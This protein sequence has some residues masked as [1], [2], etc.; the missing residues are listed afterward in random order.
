[1]EKNINEIYGANR[2]S[3]HEKSR[4]PFSNMITSTTTIACHNHRRIHV[5]PLPD[6][7]MDRGSSDDVVN[8]QRPRLSRL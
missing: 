1:M 3:M 6:S 8:D 7:A 2:G 5:E 4:K